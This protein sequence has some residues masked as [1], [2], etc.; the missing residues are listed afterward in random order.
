MMRVEDPGVKKLSQML[1]LFSK[2]MMNYA[3]Y[4]QTL[5]VAS[6]FPSL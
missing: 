5:I 2:S 6:F 3:I 4:E 1:C